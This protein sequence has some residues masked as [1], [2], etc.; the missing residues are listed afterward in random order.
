MPADLSLASWADDL[1]L[2][3]PAIPGMTCMAIRE[4]DV[5]RLAAEMLLEKIAADGKPVESRI[6]CH[7]LCEGRSV[8]APYDEGDVHSQESG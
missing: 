2:E 8:A 4:Y 7:Q 1:E 5:G 3:R 6:V